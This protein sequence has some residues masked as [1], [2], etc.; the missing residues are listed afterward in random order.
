M[1]PLPLLIIPAVLL[2]L[3]FIALSLFLHLEA[4]KHIPRELLPEWRLMSALMSFFLAGYIL[5]LVIQ[6][7]EIAFPLE[8][9]TAFV[10]LGGGLFVLVITRITLRSLKQIAA[11]EKELEEINRELQQS[12]YEL[13]RAYDSTIEGWGLALDLRDRET[14]GHSQ[15]VAGMTR[16]I[17]RKVGMSEE[18]I[19]H[20]TRGALLHDIGKMAVSDKVLMKEGELT[21]EERA[22]M[23]KHP[24]HAYEMLSSIQYLKPA[25]DIPYCHH[26]RWDGY[27]YPRG[28]KGDEIPL[29]ARIF[30]IA[31]TWDAL[32]S[33]RR[34]HMPWSKEK[35]CQHIKSQSGSHFDPELVDVF[36]KME[37]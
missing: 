34:Y 36:L 30:A 4:A 11:H 12:N 2:G 5:F 14:E 18:D 10:F 29:A 1:E 19:V 22:L 16:A 35:V 25:L 7:L 31:D 32:S 13:V 23:R 20:L 8:I 24:L 6:I 3:L 28:L 17:A 27:G 26:E 21:A 37:C 33:K 15:R 9:L